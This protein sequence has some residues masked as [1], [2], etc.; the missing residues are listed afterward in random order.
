[1]LNVRFLDLFSL[2]YPG[3]F[4]FMCLLVDCLLIF[5]IVMRCIVSSPLFVESFQQLLMR[6]VKSIELIALHY[7]S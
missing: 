1:M 2:L 6:I 5:V 4:N 7:E 3:T